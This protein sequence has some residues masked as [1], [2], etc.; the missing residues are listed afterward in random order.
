MSDLTTDSDMT[1]AKI[2]EHYDQGY[3]FVSE[4]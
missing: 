3:G 1:A 4:R 2:R